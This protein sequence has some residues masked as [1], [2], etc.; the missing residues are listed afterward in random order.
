MMQLTRLGLAADHPQPLD[1]QGMT[2]GVDDIW[3][4]DSVV[5]RVVE[6]SESDEI[7]FEVMYPIDWENNRFAERTIVFTDVLDYTVAEGPFA[8][9]PTILQVTQ[10]GE[11]KDRGI[12]RIETNAGVRTLL[13]KGI[14]IRD[15]WG[16]V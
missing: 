8:G 5:Y 14:Q 15:G 4:H 16:A 6:N 11:E 12:L 10:G 2:L 3:F 9:K 1:G 13:C 7:G